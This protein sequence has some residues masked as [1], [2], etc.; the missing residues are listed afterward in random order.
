MTITTLLLLY[1]AFRIKQYTCDF[2]LQ[3]NWIGQ[4]K[5]LPNIAGHQAL[6]IHIL[7]HAIGTAIVM[8]IFAPSFWWLGLVDFAIHGII[9]KAKAMLNYMTKWNMEHRGFWLALG[10]DQELHNFTH[11]AYILYLIH[12]LGGVQV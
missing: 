7:F 5:G 8:L 10:F 4:N 2:I 11:L 12:T 9:D 6:F 3:N 1:I